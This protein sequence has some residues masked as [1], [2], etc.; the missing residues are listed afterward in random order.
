[1]KTPFLALLLA[2][3]LPLSATVVYSGEQNLAVAW[4]D[5]EGVYVNVATGATAVVWPEDFDNAP[6]INLTL[7]GYG[8]FNSELVKPWGLSGGES[9]DPEQETD[10]YLNLEEGT[11]V[12]SSGPFLESA[13]GSQ[14]HV[15]I[16]AEPG[17]FLVGEDGFFGFTFKEELAGD[18]YYGWLRFSP[19]NSGFGTLVD[20]AFEDTPG[21]GIEVGAVPEPSGALLTAA[22]GLMAVRRRRA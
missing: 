16:A 13:W 1:M 14:F 8:I 18:T 9:Y 20:W 4:D 3:P 6:W 10:Y 5:L 19:D 12:D 2:S 22:L 21:Q 17:K 11:I 7:G 15:E